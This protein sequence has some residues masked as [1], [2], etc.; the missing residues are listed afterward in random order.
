M[1]NDKAAAKQR[2][3]AKHQ[4]GQQREKKEAKAPEDKIPVTV[5]TG[6]LGSGKTVGGVDRCIH[7]HSRCPPWC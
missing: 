2:K 1:A 5:L 4:K 3:G 7:T 6:F